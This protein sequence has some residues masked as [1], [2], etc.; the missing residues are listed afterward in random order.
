M[1]FD[2][3]TVTLDVGTTKNGKGRVLPFAELDELRKA[4]EAQR[5]ERDRL[6]R[7]AVICRWVFHRNGKQIKAHDTAWKTAC[8]RAGVPE[9]VAMKIT[10][11]KT[12]SVFDRYNVVSDA[13]LRDATQRLNAALTGQGT[14][15][16][17][18]QQNEPTIDAQT[19]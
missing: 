8:R 13:D 17:T 15:Q 9:V 14:K 4:L 11:H 5:D 16:G 18:G 19:A 3:G 10:G 12:R 1:D 2:A 7:D 6:K